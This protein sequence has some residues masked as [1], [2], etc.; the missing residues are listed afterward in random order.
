ML[1]VAELNFLKE[2]FLGRNKLIPKKKYFQKYDSAFLLILVLKSIPT[3]IV[4]L[5]FHPFFD[6]LL[7]LYVSLLM[8]R[9]KQW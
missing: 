5:F 1:F 2:N 6:M 8:T 3:S 9:I 7:S 4:F